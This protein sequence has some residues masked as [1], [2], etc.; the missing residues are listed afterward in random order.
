L[1]EREKN[2]QEKEIPK[3]EQLLTGCIGGILVSYKNSR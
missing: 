1:K 2:L 3:K